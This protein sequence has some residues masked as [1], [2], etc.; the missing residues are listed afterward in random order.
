MS[1]IDFALPVAE[2]GEAGAQT[3]FIGNMGAPLR[4]GADDVMEDEHV[5]ISQNPLGFGLDAGAEP[6]TKDNLEDADANEANL[7]PSDA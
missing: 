1:S 5:Y 7:A 2:N 6:S 3:S 4:T